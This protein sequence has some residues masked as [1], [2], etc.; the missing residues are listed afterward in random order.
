MFINGTMVTPAG[1]KT[2]D[3]LSALIEEAAAAAGTSSA[4]PASASP[5]P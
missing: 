5:A 4:S 2:V 3:E 1:L